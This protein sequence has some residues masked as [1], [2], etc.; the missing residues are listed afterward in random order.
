MTEQTT[1]QVTDE[2]DEIEEPVAAIR[3]R[4]GIWLAVIALCLIQF[5]DVMCVTVVVTTLPQMLA[6][7]GA[8]AAD[9]TL[10][11][12]AYAMFFGGL[13]LFG[14]RLGDRFGQRKCILVSLAVFAAGSLIAAIAPSALVLA[15]AR[16]VQGAA[17]AA[18]VPA[19]LKLLTTVTESEEARA[20]AVAGWSAAGAAAGAVGY[21]VGG[22]VTDLGSWRLIFWGLLALSAF[23]AAAILTLIRPTLHTHDGQ[24]LNVKASTLFT[25][26][27]ML[28][29]VGTTLLGEPSSRLLALVLLG[30][31]VVT[32]GLFYVADHRS[33]APLL[34]RAVLGRRQVRR[35]TAGG[36]INTATT[37][38]AATLLTLY[39]QGTLGRGP[40]TAAA[41]L[42]P[43]SLSVIAGSAAAARL[44]V[45]HSNER[46]AA[47]GLAL[48]GA[49]IGLLMVNPGATVV[50]G[51]TMAVTGFGLGLSSVATTA[52]AT[53]VPEEP[54]AMASGIVNT[55][56]QLGT[57]IGTAAILLVATATTGVPGTDTGTPYYG[58]LAAVAL[59]GISALAFARL[60]VRNRR[61]ARRAAAG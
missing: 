11:A 38:G 45:R 57:A 53:D 41:T 8:R 23:Q 25:A 55:G 52:M 10:I 61:A 59:A 33:S 13:L 51:S 7:V 32:T 14:A 4:P 17:A 42:L 58:W 16:C 39:L 29:V 2:A 47:A 50:V 21:V 35:G 28:V 5:V 46:V 18:A 22:V 43:L 36:F 3:T 54:R 30:L 1:E 12:T 60:H 6:D 19:A 56:A 37:T 34:P 31:A 9:S 44:I 24:S 15:A 49:G 26:A 20:K 40:V 48:I 27:I